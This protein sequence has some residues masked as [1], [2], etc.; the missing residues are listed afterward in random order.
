MFE[1]EI[2][3]IFKNQSPENP[4]KDLLIQ[5]ISF[6]DLTTL[7]G[8]DNDESIVRL[9][10]KA[11]AMGEKG[12]PF[13]AAVCVY[14]PYIKRVKQ[15]L[16][17]T[18]IKTATVTGFFPSAQAPLFLKLEEVK[19]AV[20][21]GA[22]EL[23][24]VI[25]RGKLLEGE[26]TYVFDEIAAI[27][28]LAQNIHL[29]V[30]LETGE[31]K[32]PELIRKASEIAIAAGADFIKTSTGKSIP[33]VTEE[34]AYIILKVI[35]EHYLKTGIKKG[36]KPAGGISNPIQAMKYY[37]MIK[38]I[39]GEEWLTSDLFRIGASRLVDNLLKEILT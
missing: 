10:Q 38:H 17:E 15:L 9:C 33:A 4:G 27:R 18:K 31:L 14:S 28:D 16:S 32:T 35:K 19:F 22:D 11:L 24:M 2:R 30:I 13:P 36:F 37:L 20:G 34:A 6:L 25:S 29:K 3:T 12:L 21:E 5:L 8:T 7:E 1:K 39:S 23:D 26:E